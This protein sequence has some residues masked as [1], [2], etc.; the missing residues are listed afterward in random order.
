VRK[1]HQVGSPELA[2]FCRSRLASFKRPESI[3]FIDA[4]PKNPLGKILRK[5]LRAPAGGI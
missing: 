4:L 2:D 1:G 3:E 5:D